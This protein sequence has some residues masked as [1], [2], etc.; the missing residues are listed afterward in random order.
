MEIDKLSLRRVVSWVRCI[1]DEKQGY[2]P[3]PANS[4]DE[5]ATDKYIKARFGVL[6]HAL[7][8]VGHTSLLKPN[9]ILE[10]A[11][12]RADL[13]EELYEVY[14][15]YLRSIF[16]TKPGGISQDWWSV[17]TTLNPPS[18]GWPNLVFESGMLNILKGVV[19]H[20]ESRLGLYF[21]VLHG[22]MKEYKA[23]RAEQKELINSGKSVRVLSSEDYFKSKGWAENCE[24]HGSVPLKELLHGKSSPSDALLR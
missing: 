3:A 7:M 10:N 17:L 2:F 24:G 6:T 1:D 14:A 18:N 9:G 11:A 16:F 5:R 22:N 21:K 8:R 4:E 19:P 23:Y 13:P 15:V 12:K 20:E